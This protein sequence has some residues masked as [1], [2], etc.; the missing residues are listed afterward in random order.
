MDAKLAIP[1][2]LFE[3]DSKKR[4]LHFPNTLPCAECSIIAVASCLSCPEI[5]KQELHHIY[6]SRLLMGA[7]SPQGS[8]H[9]LDFQPP[10]QRSSPGHQWM[11]GKTSACAL[12]ASSRV[13]LEPCEDV[14]LNKD[15]YID[16]RLFHSDTTGE[17]WSKSDESLSHSKI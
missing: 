12:A 16:L 7:L 8:P 3:C 13:Q 9:G 17:R 15:G 2:L 5:K 6:C 14:A 1:F 4:C 11:R 10:R